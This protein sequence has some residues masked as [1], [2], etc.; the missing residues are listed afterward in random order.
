MSK[1]LEI[2]VVFCLTLCLVE[3]AFP[4]VVPLDIK[5]LLKYRATVSTQEVVKCMLAYWR[6]IRVVTQ[7]VACLATVCDVS[8]EEPR[9]LAEFS[10]EI[11]YCHFFF[12]FLS[13]RYS[14]HK[15]KFTLFSMQVYEF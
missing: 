1:G 13:L 9:A 3:K 8:G 14:L 6:N 7:P 11:C 2:C 10:A 12:L 5:V 15:I 4:V